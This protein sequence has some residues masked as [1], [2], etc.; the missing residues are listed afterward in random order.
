MELGNGDEGLQAGENDDEDG[1]NVDIIEQ[2]DD[3]SRLEPLQWQHL[4]QNVVVEQVGDGEVGE[5]SEEVRKSFIRKWTLMDDVPTSGLTCLICAFD[6]TVTAEYRSRT[7]TRSK[8]DRHL[9]GEFHSRVKEVERV[10][11]AQPGTHVDCPLCGES[12]KK[13][14]GV[15][16]IR[17]EHAE[18]L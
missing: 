17:K 8:L 3:D 11:E 9:V 5:T 15:K 6:N 10:F 16:H 7:W 2:A 13:S 18:Q 14:L 4:P 12:V 1:L